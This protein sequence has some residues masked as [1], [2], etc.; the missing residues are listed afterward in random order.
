MLH[1]YDCHISYVCVCVI[2]VITLIVEKRRRY[3]IND[4][5]QELGS[6]LPDSYNS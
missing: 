3:K 6:M 2:N 5:I 4:C 1:C